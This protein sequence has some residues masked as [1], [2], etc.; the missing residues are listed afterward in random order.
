M[1]ELLPGSQALLE[2]QGFKQYFLRKLLELGVVTYT[3]KNV[4]G[5]LNA[6]KSAE[7]RSSRARNMVVPDHRLPPGPDLLTGQPRQQKKVLPSPPQSPN[8]FDITTL[9]RSRRGRKSASSS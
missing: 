5:C 3:V 6:A 1:L 9:F 4:S 7:W 8:A 2:S